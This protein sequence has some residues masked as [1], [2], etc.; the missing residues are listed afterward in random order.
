LP[1]LAALTGAVIMVGCEGRRRTSGPA[2]RAVTFEHD[3]KPLMETRCA[4]CHAEGGI[5][6][7]LTGAAQV[8]EKKEAVVQAV[9]TRRMPVWLA[10]A[11][12]QTYE[13]DPTLTDGEIE[14]FKLWRAG[15]YQVGEPGAGPPQP[16]LLRDLSADVALPLLPKGEA[17][18]PDPARPDQYRC[19]LIDWPHADKSVFMTGFQAVPGNPRVVHHLVAYS[20]TSAVAGVVRALDAEEDGPG[21][22]CF[23]GALPDR[24][25]D[26][27]VWAR[28]S[29]DYP[30][31]LDEPRNA[32]W[33]GH[34]A[35]GMLGNALPADTGVLI[36]QGSAIVVQ[37]HFYTRTAPNEG[38]SGSEI[39][40]TL[41]DHVAKPGFFMPF[42]QDDWL[43]GKETG[44][45]VVPPGQEATVSMDAPLAHLLA[46]ARRPEF[47]EVAKMEIHSANL[48]MHSYGKSAE[49]YLIRA[50]GTRETL[51]EIPR[52]DLAWQRDYAFAAPKV[53]DVAEAAKVQLGV[54]CTFAN[55]TERT[56]YGGLGS[57]DEMCFDF[58]F[59]ALVPA[60]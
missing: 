12:H 4:G 54:R 32:R 34:W 49:A 14:I 35:P 51:L 42:S 60:R 9:E 21:Y 17:F 24:L 20:V 47:G 55:P 19:F 6:F 8:L 26:P 7:A 43:A 33:L 31:V 18:T 48:H 38:D 29:R 36:P 23:G 11:G 53:F 44:T 16:A 28:V 58:P 13:E 1:L 41:A 56:V 15:G 40:M 2:P 50:D 57:D 3:V 22:Q 59:I 45:L 39:R 52:W 30:G 5:G 46:Y 10:A 37:V 25:S 27:D